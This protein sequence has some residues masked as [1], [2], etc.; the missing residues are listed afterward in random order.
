MDIT[1]IT[2]Q[3]NKVL[4]ELITRLQN[5]EDFIIEQTPLVIQELLTW[6]FALSLIW[7]CIG[8]LLIFMFAITFKS[9]WTF[10]SKLEKQTSEKGVPTLL[11]VLIQSLLLVVPALFFIFSNLVW[12]QILIAPR[13]YLLEYASQLTK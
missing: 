13:V 7:H 5:A 12:L 4:P 1:T 3:A 8:W 2:E 11:T 6:N 9:V 10:R